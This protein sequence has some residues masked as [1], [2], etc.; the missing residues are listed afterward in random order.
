MWPPYFFENNL[1][2][3]EVILRNKK[4]LN[5][6]NSNN[7]GYDLLSSA[8]SFAVS[9]FGDI[10]KYGIDRSEIPWSLDS[11]TNSFKKTDSYSNMFVV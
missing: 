1:E 5:I 9:F 6:N 8:F 2:R 4:L 3:D 11:A 7:Y 10:N